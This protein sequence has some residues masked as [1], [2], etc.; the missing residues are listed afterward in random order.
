MPGFHHQP[1]TE[2]EE[3]QAVRLILRGEQT[4]GEIARYLGLSLYQVKR[5]EQ[6]HKVLENNM[7]SVITRTM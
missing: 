5:I 2:W 3:R 1:P 4:L 6:K 7:P